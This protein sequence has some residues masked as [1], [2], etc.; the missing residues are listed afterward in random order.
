MS[1]DHQVALISFMGVV[2]YAILILASVYL[3]WLATR[4]V[5]SMEKTAEKLD[6]RQ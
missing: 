4:F 5:R 3:L 6:P 1:M 2:Y